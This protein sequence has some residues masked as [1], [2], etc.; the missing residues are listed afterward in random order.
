LDLALF[1][2]HPVL[3]SQPAQLLLL[4]AGQAIMATAVVQVGLAQPVPQRLLR[5]P[6]LL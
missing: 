2:Q 4:A 6:Q 3:P 5:H 1:A